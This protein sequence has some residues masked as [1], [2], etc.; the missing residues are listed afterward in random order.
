MGAG[1]GLAA[2]DMYL[3]EGGGIRHYDG[4]TLGPQ[5][6]IPSV[7]VYSLRGGGGAMFGRCKGGEILK[8][9]GSTWTVLTTIANSSALWA[10]GPND[11]Y[12]TARDTIHH[13]NGSTWTQATVTGADLSDI[14]GASASELYAVGQGG[15]VVRGTGTTWATVTVPTT[16]NLV[17]VH[18]TAANDV[19]VAGED[20]LLHFDGTHWTPIRPGPLNASVVWPMIEEIVVLD[21]GTT[22]HTAIR[23]CVTCL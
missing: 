13:Y 4:N 14:W 3:T 15:V 11:L 23:A 20:A 9:V 5:M 7:S 2:N 22:A 17:S 10:F 19:F 6:T 18:G 1:W 8:L 16:R 12:V 21:S